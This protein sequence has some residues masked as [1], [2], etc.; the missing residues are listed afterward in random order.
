[1]SRVW[2][3]GGSDNW[4]GW[5][6]YSLDVYD[7]LHSVYFPTVAAK[8]FWEGGGI[9]MKNSMQRGLDVFVHSFMYTAVQRADSIG[10][11]FNYTMWNS[12][13][14]PADCQTVQHLR[15]TRPR[16]VWLLLTECH[17]P[18]I[19]A[20]SLT[21]GFEIPGLKVLWD[22]IS[23]GFCDDGSWQVLLS[24]GWRNSAEC[25]SCGELQRIVLRK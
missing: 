3:L 15:S 17:D 8:F 12:A 9:S 6:I 10:L 20:F 5:N 25:L 1:M 23:E 19:S 13:S 16:A 7:L 14:G 11:V 22:D 2:T 18:K 21:G 4:H 24:S